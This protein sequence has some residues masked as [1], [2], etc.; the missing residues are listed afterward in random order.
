MQL[1]RVRPQ[2]LQ[3]TLHATELSSLIAAARLALAESAGGM[4]PEAREHLQH[5]LD[6]YDAQVAQLG[7]R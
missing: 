6:A 4:A 7:G 1:A 2:V 5:V 3:L